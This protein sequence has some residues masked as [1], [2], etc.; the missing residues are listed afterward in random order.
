MSHSCDVIAGQSTTKDIA[1]MVESETGEI[2]RL[3]LVTNINDTQKLICES[4]H[5]QKENDARNSGPDKEITST[6]CQ[7]TELGYIR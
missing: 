7:F 1:S 6:K 4:V 5:L 2:I 3:L